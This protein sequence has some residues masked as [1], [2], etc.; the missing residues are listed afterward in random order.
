MAQG[1]QAALEALAGLPQE[2]AAEAEA[3]ATVLLVAT[4]LRAAAF[5]RRLLST[6]LLLLC[7]D[8]ADPRTMAAM[9]GARVS[10][11]HAINVCDVPALD[12]GNSPLPSLRVGP[13]HPALSAEADYLLG[14]AAGC[15]QNNATNT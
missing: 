7:V 8:D 5:P 11:A 2:K 12:G 15:L 13:A 6:P 9:L 3:A 14:A 4:W 1:T 10:K